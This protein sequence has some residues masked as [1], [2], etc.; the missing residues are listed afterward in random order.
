MN[1]LF[2]YTL[3]L[4]L[5]VNFIKPILAQDKNVIDSIKH[6]LETTKKDTAW[7]RTKILLGQYVPIMRTGYWD[8][9][10]VEAAELK[11]I[12]MQATALFNI[13]YINTNILNDIDK[14]IHYFKLSFTKIKETK[15]LDEIGTWAFDIGADNS[16]YKFPEIAISYLNTALNYFQQTNNRSKIPSVYSTL[17]KIYLHQG[18]IPKAI[19]IYN[20]ELK[21]VDQLKDPGADLSICLMSLGFIYK[22][23]GN[24]SLALNYF[25]KSL[26]HS[27][28]INAKD[29]IG[30]SLNHIGLIY[31][32]RKNYTTALNYF[33]KSLKVFES[34]NDKANISTQLN[35]IG[36]VYKEQNK[37]SEALIT[38]KKA[39]QLKKEVYDNEGIAFVQKNIGAIYFIQK[40]YTL[41]Y[42]F[43]D[44]ALQLS[45]SIG[46]PKNI[47]LSEFVL[48]QIDSA[49]GNYKG[50][51]DHFKFF[52]KYRDSIN[53]ETTRKAS[54]TNQIKNEYEKKAAADSIKTANEKNLAGIK[55]KQEQIQKYYLYGGLGITTLLGFFIYSRLRITKKQKNIIDEQ[56]R[57]VEYQKEMVEEKQKE[58]YDS[59]TYAKR[60][61]KAILPPTDFI[62]SNLNNNFVLYIPKDIVAG[63]FY[64]A[65]KMNDLFFIA[66]A[67]STGHGVPG[68][69]VSVVCS[70]ALNRAVKEFELRE[71]GKI[72]DKTRELVIE[73]FEK[74]KDEVKDGMD[75]SLL[76]IDS[77]NK[78]I[79]WSGANNPL[80]YIQDNELKEIKADKQPIG[81][82][83]HPKPF[84]THQIEYKEN[85]TF[86][87][88]T[89]G[90]ADQFGGPNGKKFKYKQF[91]DLLLK[92]NNLSPNQ[93]ADLINQA[94][95]EWKGDLEQVDDVCVIGVKL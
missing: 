48:S 90:L 67:D 54:I 23:Q 89:D 41:A 35:N 71:T 62:N 76:C 59:I 12:K 24:D 72:L 81:K 93:Q 16:N 66:A 78:N 32:Q 4:L 5:C 27:E 87:L 13:G 70:N 49:K 86:Y 42:L 65:E 6:V 56:K 94:F 73:T 68:A 25:N 21:F 45:K 7:L 39:L 38:Y 17:A 85:S 77:K 40:N 31:L 33:L 64:W 84:T 22:N 15:N 9:I 69:M 60:L 34:I 47:Y 43:A 92:N 3:T 14:G 30:A 52:V 95:S 79:F 53:N 11:N 51:Y 26:R 55:L 57:V 88:F 75:I 63:D 29:E 83:D 37:Y 28:K 82:S 58:I 44:S 61:Q 18:N 1:A 10:S 50:A 20:T 2:K 8:T 80:W 36:T 91:S 19:E 74:S 46:F